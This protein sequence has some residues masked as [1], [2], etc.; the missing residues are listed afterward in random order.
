VAE[1]ADSALVVSSLL[2]GIV[3]ADPG[4]RERAADEVCD[5]VMSLGEFAPAVSWALV[6]ARSVES[7]VAA[8]EAQL[9]ALAQVRELVGLSDD[10]LGLIRRRGGSWRGGSQDEYVAF[11][12]EH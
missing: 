11:L 4:E 9:H 12:T 3:S 2:K 6:L 7:S 1:L 10:V 5:V 8:Q